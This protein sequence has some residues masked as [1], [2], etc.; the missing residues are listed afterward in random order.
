MLNAQ[1]TTHNATK[2]NAQRICVNK[3]GATRKEK[4]ED[5][6]RE[7]LISELREL[8]RDLDHQICDRN[9]RR[10][11]NRRH[12]TLRRRLEGGD[13]RYNTGVTIGGIPTEKREEFGVRRGTQ[14]I[15]NLLRE[16]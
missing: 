8:E 4:D 1:R 11:M 14:K 10:R 5:R 3:N 7:S 12:R 2:H 9:R 6:S 15:L 13:A 16:D